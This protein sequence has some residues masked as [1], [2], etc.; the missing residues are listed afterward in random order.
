VFLG[1]I[2][3]DP[4]NQQ[5][6]L[7]VKSDDRPYVGLVGEEIVAPSGRARVQVGNDEVQGGQRRFVVFTP[8]E[9]ASA[10]PAAWVSR[11][12]VDAAGELTVQGN[13][14]IQGNLMIAGGAVEFEGG[15]AR[16]LAAPP[17]DI[18]HF[19]DANSDAEELRI[20]MPAPVAGGV[21]G[22]NRVVIGTWSKHL[23]A[24]GAE[25]EEFH[26]CLTIRDDCTVEVSG[27]LVVNG[28]ITAEAIVGGRL[29]DA[30]R[31]AATA[32]LA[33]GILATSSRL[34]GIPG[35]GPANARITP[36]VVSVDAVANRLEA[37]QAFRD[38]FV[39]R[40]KNSPVLAVTIAKP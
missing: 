38:A 13:T 1:Q 27:N 20:E 28:Q 26:P 22:N 36:A 14:S 9:N 33:S 17:W 18:Y 19:S 10:Q 30:A 2:I 15:P 35:T 34:A 24:T 4:T 3:N 32:A 5:Q 12:E 21:T 8:D 7:A 25:K 29:T 37:D 23:D 40:M 6:P 16:D 11:L 31:N 39:E